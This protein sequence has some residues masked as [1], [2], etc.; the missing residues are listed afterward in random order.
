MASAEREIDLD[1]I[2]TF[3][4]RLGRDAGK[5]LDDAWRLRAGGG[6]SAQYVDKDS[7]VDIVTQTDEDVEAFIKS[8]ITKSFPCHQ[9]IGEETYGK[10]ASKDYLIGDEPTWCVDPLD[11]TVN[12][13][14][15]FPMFCVSIG[16]ILN[17]EP[18]VGVIVAPFLNQTFSACRGKGAWL[19]ESQQL[20]LMRNPIPPM[21]ETAPKGCVFSCEWGKD[22]R[23]TADGNLHRK[24]ESFLN[25]AAEIGGR[26]GKG[27]MVHGRLTYG[28]KAAAGEHLDWR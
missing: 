7:S 3:A 26:G 21:P 17:G 19:N 1:K 5:M 28:G 22:R 10:G 18:V 23:D 12:F 11:G 14:H 4:L 16:F 27:G 2:Y 15:I 6:G 9:F 20:P 24:V 8:S 13:T 25:M